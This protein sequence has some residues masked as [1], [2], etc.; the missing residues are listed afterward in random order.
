[1]VLDR[2]LTRTL[3]CFFF[4]SFMSMSSLESYDVAIETSKGRDNLLT[5]DE[6]AMFEDLSPTITSRLV[7]LTKQYVVNVYVNV[8]TRTRTRTRTRTN[9]FLNTFYT[10]ES[11]CVNTLI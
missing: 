5:Y 3:V 9:T 10:G 7:T 1:M 11:V 8:H 2:C 6:R 4:L